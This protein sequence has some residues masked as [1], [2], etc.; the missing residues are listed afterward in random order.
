[1]LYFRTIIDISEHIFWIN[2]WNH[3]PL[4]SVTIHSY[5]HWWIKRR[6]SNVIFWFV[7]ILKLNK[8]LTDNFSERNENASLNCKSLLQFND[9]SNSRYFLLIIARSLSL[10][11]SLSFSFSLSLARSLFLSYI[12]SMTLPWLLSWLFLYISVNSSCWGAELLYNWVCHNG[13]M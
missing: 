11:L 5:H 9:W 2:L 8:Y 10:S 1:M 7:M 13:T 12:P 3:T 4:Y 6:K